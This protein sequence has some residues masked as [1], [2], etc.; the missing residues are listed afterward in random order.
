[1]GLA[2]LASKCMSNDQAFRCDGRE[3]GDKLPASQTIVHIFVGVRYLGGRDDF[4]H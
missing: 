4:G 2:R 3:T 1:M